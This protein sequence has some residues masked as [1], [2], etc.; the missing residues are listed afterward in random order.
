MGKR[1]PREK[2]GE[3]GRGRTRG[4]REKTGQRQPHVVGLN[5]KEK[6]G[7]EV[8]PLGW[9]SSVAGSGMRTA[10]ERHRS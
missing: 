9:R 4:P 10:E 1:E 3:M 6:R 5:K 2:W 8:K 7:R